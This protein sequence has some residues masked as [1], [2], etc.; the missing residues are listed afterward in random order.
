MKI[1]KHTEKLILNDWFTYHPY[2]KPTKT[3]YY[4]FNIA[5]E[6]YSEFQKD[7]KYQLKEFLSIDE[8]KDLSIITTC[9]FEDI[10]SEI[11]IWRVFIEKHK[12]LYQKYLPFYKLDDYYPNE[13]NIQDI[14][15]IIWYYISAFEEDKILNPISETIL[16]IAN[17]IFEIL[18]KYY[19]TAPE[20]ELMQDFFNI[21]STETDYYNLRKKINFLFIGSYLFFINKE[22]FFNEGLE[23]INSAKKS[24][25]EENTR[26]YLNELEDIYNINKR[27]NLLAL[28]GCQWLAGIL[29]ITHPRYHDLLNLSTKKSGVFLYEGYDSS[30]IFLKHIATNKQIKITR[31][32]LDPDNNMIPGKSAVFIGLVNWMNEWWFSGTYSV[33]EYSDN[34]FI[35]EKNN[36]QSLYLFQD[37]SEQQIIL[38]LQLETFLENSNNSPIAF[39]SRK[40]NMEEFLNNYFKKYNKKI[41]KNH[42]KTPIKDF[43]S[44]PNELED[45]SFICYFNPKAG[46]EIIYGFNIFIPDKNNPDFDPDTLETPL[47]ILSSESVSAD[48]AKYVVENYDIKNLSFSNER[49]QNTLLENF[50]FLLRFWK[51]DNY[52]ST[53]QITIYNSSN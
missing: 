7:S 40:A 24:N 46:L 5:K 42:N 21:E 19:E 47:E 53:P 22:D 41:D 49:E 9:Y 35:E 16:F 37:L 8:I 12:E 32:S 33:F 44:V 29:G 6:I 34:I 14:C 20:N 23:M 1:I 18:D 48:F 45:N 13:I 30:N 50:D 27:S 43:S 11:G 3:D 26:L 15:F 28:R 25:N 52:F 17:S 51:R 2:N 39:F 10:I 38:D 36:P 4:Y 31:K